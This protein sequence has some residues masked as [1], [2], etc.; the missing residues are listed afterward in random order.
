MR[1]NARSLVACLL[2]SALVPIASCRG[3]RADARDT[4]A[5]DTADGW[6]EPAVF[7]FA[8]AA[9]SLLLNDAEIGVK[10]ARRAPVKQLATRMQRDYRALAARTDSLSER[11]SV[12]PS[13]S[14]G[15]DFAAQHRAAAADLSNVGRRPFDERYLD[16]VVT[17]HQ[18]VMDRMYE[19]LSAAQDESVRRLLEDA[20]R[21]L[22]ANL[23]EAT[24]LKTQ[25]G[26]ATT[27]G[28]S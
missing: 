25:G 8:D 6:S 20:Q 17:G 26:R 9:F 16:H 10:S 5:L 3:N 21:R 4:L 2:V 11:R 14:P 1:V 12:V 7:G 13:S 18:R 15:F 23:A 27:R 19:A 24:R 28:R 22:E